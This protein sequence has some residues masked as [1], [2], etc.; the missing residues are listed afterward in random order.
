MRLI[1]K[2]RKIGKLHEASVQ[3]S[4]RGSLQSTYSLFGKFWSLHFKEQYLQGF[5]VKGFFNSTK[6][7]K[8][9][10]DGLPYFYKQM[11][12]TKNV[13]YFK[14]QHC[15][16]KKW[17][18]LSWLWA[19]NFSSV[20]IIEFLLNNNE[21]FLIELITIPCKYEL[22]FRIEVVLNEAILHRSCS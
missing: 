15:S 4:C 19:A 22:S 20:Q 8:N 2:E 12:K 1:L 7:V 3:R 11:F 10:W 14:C 17:L 13:F 6:V 5:C 9:L 18:R 21:L 16:L